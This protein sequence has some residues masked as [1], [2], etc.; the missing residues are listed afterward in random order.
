M[1]F[2]FPAILQTI[3][4]LLRLESPLLTNQLER[5]MSWRKC[6]FAESSWNDCFDGLNSEGFTKCLRGMCFKTKW[7]EKVLKVYLSLLCIAIFS[8]CWKWRLKQWWKEY[9]IDFHT[10][11]SVKSIKEWKS[12]KLQK[13]ANIGLENGETVLKVYQHMSLLCIAIFS[14]LKKEKKEWWKGYLI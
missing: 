10:F 1:P 3:L 8:Y 14:Q 6:V 13:W 4:V 7:W 9:L 11:L 12:L 5:Y 2:W